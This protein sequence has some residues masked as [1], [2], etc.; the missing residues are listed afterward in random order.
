MLK[1][2]YPIHYFM[3][4]ISTSIICFVPKLQPW[5]K[6]NSYYIIFFMIQVVVIRHP[7]ERKSKCSLAPLHKLSGITFHNA[8][9][10]FRFDATGYILLTLNASPLTSQDSGHPFIILDSTWHLIPKLETCIKGDPLRRSLPNNIKTAYPRIS[11]IFEDPQ[12]GLASIEALYVAMKIVG[13]NNPALLNGYHW[14]EEFLSGLI[15][16]QNTD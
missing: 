1:C 3:N 12:G 6:L 10:N 15:E 2:D 8:R 9:E 5:L 11:K 4:D 16:T 14:K 7:K 13:E